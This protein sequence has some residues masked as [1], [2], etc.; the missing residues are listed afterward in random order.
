V[1]RREGSGQPGLFF[2]VP[3]SPD[4]RTLIM[5]KLKG[6]AMSVVKSICT[7]DEEALLGIM[8]LHNGGQ[9]FKLDPTFS[10]GAFYRGQVSAPKLKYDLFPEPGIKQADCRHLPL[11]D[12][13]I[14][15]I[16]FD[17]PMMFG[18]HGTN[19]P[20]NKIARGYSDPTTLNNRFTQ[21]ASFDELQA[22]Y[23]GAL[24]EFARILKPKGLLVFKCQDFTDSKTTMTHCRVENWAPERGFYAKDLMIRIVS[25]GRA[26]N[27]KLVQRHARKYHSY[28][29]VFVKDAR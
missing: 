13:T 15:S 2:Y 25:A 17:P 7:S 19:N 24:D 10:K 4:P 27:P 12:C 1:K 18:A 16:I 9:P 29:F 5:G 14:G 6:T 3:G 8:Q 23:T 26:Y 20:N 11:G 28:F 21:L 22:M